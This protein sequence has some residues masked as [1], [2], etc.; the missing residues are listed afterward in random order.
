MPF[1]GWQEQ[2]VFCFG[3]QGADSKGGARL[4]AEL[5]QELVHKYSVQV[6]ISGFGG[7]AL[8]PE[9][10][11]Y[12]ALRATRSRK[13]SHTDPGVQHNARLEREL[14]SLKARLQ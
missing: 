11:Q 9:S 6:G 8:D 4:V 2:H 14:S 7:F 3:Q 1:T 10:Q 12:R 13:I 5:W